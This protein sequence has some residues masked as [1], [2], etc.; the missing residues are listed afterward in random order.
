MKGWGIRK[1]V[2]PRP[3]ISPHI[4]PAI[5]GVIAT[6]NQGAPAFATIA[7][8]INDNIIIEPTERSIP[9]VTITMKTPRASIDCQDICLNTLVTFLH[10]KKTS[11]CKKCIT[12]IIMNNNNKIPYLSK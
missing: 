6:T 1:I 10:D 4:N 3:F 9:A 8:I 11:G 5:S 12:T 7:N 2:I